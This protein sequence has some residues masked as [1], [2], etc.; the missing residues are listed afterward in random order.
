MT[1]KYLNLVRVPL[2]KVEAG[3]DEVVVEEGPVGVVGLAVPGRLM[4]DEISL[5]L[6]RHEKRWLTIGNNSR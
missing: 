3:G 5:N 2:H 4:R 6:D 1:P